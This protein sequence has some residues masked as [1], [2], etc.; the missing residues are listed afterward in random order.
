[1]K[2]CQFNGIWRLS[3]GWLK[4]FLKP[5]SFCSSIVLK[6]PGITQAQEIYFTFVIDKTYTA[7]RI[8][9]MVS[10]LG[11]DG[12]VGLSYVTATVQYELNGSC[13]SAGQALFFISQELLIIEF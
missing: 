10:I 1:M 5:W 11:G 7:I 4:I 9:V 8:S 13:A 6:A 12:P 2:F 3:D